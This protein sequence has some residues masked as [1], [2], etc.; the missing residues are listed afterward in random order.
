VHVAEA[1]DIGEHLVAA[2]PGGGA[3]GA[4]GIACEDDPGLAVALA[5]I[6]I[7]RAES[8]VNARRPGMSA[9]SASCPSRRIRRSHGSSMSR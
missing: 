8:P 9:N 6:E 2:R 5:D 1:L 3:R 7:D 4:E